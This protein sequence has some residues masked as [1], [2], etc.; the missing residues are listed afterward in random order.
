MG[1][2]H[3]EIQESG[4]T[5]G[6]PG[7]DD[8]IDAWQL[9]WFDQFLRDEDT[10]ALEQEASAYLLGG[11]RWAEGGWPRAGGGQRFYLRGG[12][13]ANPR[14]SDGALAPEEPGAE[15]PD[16]FVYDP[17]SPVASAGGTSC[18]I[19]GLVPMGPAPQCDVEI[20]R[21]V[22]VYTSE[23]L[24][25]PLLL[26]GDVHAVLW[27]V[28]SAEDT[29]FTVK[30]CHVDAAGRSVNLAQGIRRARYREGFGEPL[31]LVPGEAHRFEIELGPVAAELDAGHRI[32]VQ[33]SSSD[34]PLWDRNLNRF[35]ELAELGPADAR[36]AT[37]L[38]LHDADHPS[39]VVLP[40]VES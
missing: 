5:Q 9:R 11:G 10:G 39:H 27:A 8:V 13:D 19:P 16:V 29:D 35:E 2:W 31:P 12:G 7:S 40:V 34:F 1:P 15:P 4:G 38:V 21:D 6:H 36:T 37:Q 25:R 24:P 26:L 18:C 32:R 17:L 28:S 20:R 23:P 3:H 14:L 30:L 22:L 33:V